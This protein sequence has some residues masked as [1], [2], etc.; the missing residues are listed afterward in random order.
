[1]PQS[2]EH[3]AERSQ[4]V[5][6]VR[7]EWV[8]TVAFLQETARRIPARVAALPDSPDALWLAIAS[9]KDLLALDRMIAAMRLVETPPAEIV[10]CDDIFPPDT[11]NDCLLR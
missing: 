10:R 5:P 1:M 9:G 11:N 7:E 4:V 6:G 3:K 8:M 2:P